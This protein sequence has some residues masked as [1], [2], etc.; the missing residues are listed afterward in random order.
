MWQEG[1]YG[2]KRKGQAKVG[3]V[4]ANEGSREGTKSE[5]TAMM[6][7]VKTLDYLPLYAN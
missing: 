5:H 7:C 2:D 6:Q 3:A 1:L 4:Y